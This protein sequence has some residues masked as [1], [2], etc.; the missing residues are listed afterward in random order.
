M[1][2]L[3]RQFTISEKS[4]NLQKQIT[5]CFSCIKLELKGWSWVLVARLAA[6][7]CLSNSD[8]YHDSMVEICINVL[9][10]TNAE[11]PSS[12]ICM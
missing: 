1:N 3:Q 11:T 4:C 5:H 8:G 9:W 6:T 2:S 7:I 10:S 12:I